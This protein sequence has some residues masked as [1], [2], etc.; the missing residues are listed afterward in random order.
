LDDSE[1]EDTAGAARTVSTSTTDNLPLREAA[2][3]LAAK[4]DQGKR[5]VVVKTTG[6]KANVGKKGRFVCWQGSVRSECVTQPTH[7]VEIFSCL[8]RVTT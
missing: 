2:A 5:E 6:G 4:A 8:P 1:Q 7:Q 3:R